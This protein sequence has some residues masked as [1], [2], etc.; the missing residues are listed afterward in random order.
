MEKLKNIMKTKKLALSRN[1]Y[2]C[3]PLHT[4][5]IYERTEIVRYI[6]S[7]FPSV[8][9]SPDY[10]SV[11]YFPESWFQSINL[12]NRHNMFIFQFFPFFSLFKLQAES[13]KSIFIYPFN[14][15][16]SFVDFILQTPHNIFFFAIN[17]HLNV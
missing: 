7:N 6:A 15:D 17:I 10:V 8:I 9:N 12:Y 16:P 14:S 3:T 11:K 5:I 4:A 2:G 13:I 1:R